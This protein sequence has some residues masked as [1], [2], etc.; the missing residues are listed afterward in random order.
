MTAG[1]PGLGRGGAALVAM[2]TLAGFVEG[3]LWG[4]LNGFVPLYL[5]EL[6]IRPDDVPAWT[7]I[8]TLLGT[9]VGLL[10][11]PLWGA[12]ADRYARKPVI[13]R[14]F[15]VYA[16]GCAVAALAHDMPGFLVGRTLMSLSMGNSGLMMATLNERIPPRHIGLAFALFNSA[17]PLGSFLGPLVGG[18]IVDAHGVRTLFA[19]DAALMFALT[20]LLAGGYRDSYQPTDRRSVFVLARESL[21]VVVAS[22][23]LRRLF[24]TLFCLFGGWMLVNL[25]LALIVTE[26]FPTAQ[27]ATR[28]GWVLAS[29]GVGTVVLSPLLGALGDRL[30]VWRVL[31]IGGAAQTLCWPLPMLAP[32]FVS[33]TIAWAVANGLA[34]GVFALAFAALA[35]S[36]PPTARGRVMAFAYLPMT[37]AY[38]IASAIG[39]LAPGQ[40]VAVAFPAAAA[41]TALGVAGLA[42]SRRA[43]V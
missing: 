10:T 7:S 42:W 23:R 9:G 43:P 6:G 15:V 14:S 3:V 16:L 36:A 41:L 26:R 17:G 37:G 22:A 4:Q 40:I 13:V 8:A 34:S 1:A 25:Y 21:R 18:P 12:L 5:P 28:I 27:L 20:L 11:L 31:A 24:P 19:C 35:E 38:A 39:W 32:D 2:F 30:G 33:F 29:G